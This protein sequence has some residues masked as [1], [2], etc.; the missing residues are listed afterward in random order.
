MHS[1][2]G[3]FSGASG[4]TAT[5]SFSKDLTCILS[6][7]DLTN[8]TLQV[9]ELGHVSVLLHT[10]N[11]KSNLITGRVIVAV[12]PSLPV[13]SVSLILGND[14]TCQ[15][16][17]S[18][19]NEVSSS[20]SVGV[21]TW[22]I[23]RQQIS[24]VNDESLKENSIVEVEERPHVSDTVQ[25]SADDQI[26]P[27]GEVP[28]LTGEVTLSWQK[29]LQEQSSDPEIQQ[30]YQFALD[31]CKIDTI[32]RGYFMKDGVLMRMSRRPTVPASQESSLIYQIVIPKKY[33][34]T[35]LHLAHDT[36]MAGHLGVSKTCSQVRS[37]FYWIGMSR[38]FVEAAKWYER[39]IRSLRLFYWCRSQW[40]RNPFIMW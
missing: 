38:S 21:V 32:T 27:E 13:Q 5:N 22:A 17:I 33:R 25:K 30:L 20:I 26:V 9:A 28:M 7:S 15:R 8:I 10:V 19:N 35:V 31:E 2:C 3:F 34:N 36:P 37:Q 18:S 16:V 1:C 39:L 6:G 12:R 11:L 29:L 40:P 4:K 24:E 23:S 14:L